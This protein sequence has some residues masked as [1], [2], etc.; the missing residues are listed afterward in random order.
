MARTVQLLEDRVAVRLTGWTR[1][2]ALSDGIEIPYAA[3]RRVSARPFRHAALKVVGADLPFRAY[4]QGL[5]RLRGAWAFLSFEDTENTLTL[6]LEGLEVAIPGFF[7][8]VDCRM[9]VV[10]V[11]D[12]RATAEAIAIRSGALMESAEAVPAPAPEGRGDE[13]SP[14]D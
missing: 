1:M 7:G 2:A 13:A 14:G 3:I 6:E 12:P 8:Q 9:V 11:D 10:G 4:K 5:F